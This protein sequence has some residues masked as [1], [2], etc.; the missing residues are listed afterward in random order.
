[1]NLTLGYVESLMN[2]RK[3]IIKL[4]SIFFILILYTMFIAPGFTQDND[5]ENPLLEEIV[6]YH[7]DPYQMIFDSAKSHDI[8]IYGEIHTMAY[9]KEIFAGSIKKLHFDYG[10]NYIA[11]EIGESCQDIINEY[12]E[13][14]N[15]LLLRKN[16]WTLFS[17]WHA[18]EQYLK[19]YKTVYQ[20]NQISERK[21]R[22]ICM[23]YD[24]LTYSNDLTLLRDR[25]RYMMEVLDREV[26]SIDKSA[27]LL[28]LIG[29]YHA[30]KSNV[31]EYMK[32]IDSEGLL[33]KNDPLGAFLQKRF[34]A[35]VFSFYIDGIIPDVYDDEGFFQT[36]I[37]ELYSKQML[38]MSAI[39]F[40]LLFD[41]IPEAFHLNILMKIPIEGNF[42]GYIFTGDSEELKRID[43]N[44]WKNKK[45]K[46]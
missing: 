3:T 21:M 6:R 2:N 28:I 40:A 45:D 39:P 33:F 24:P 44:K 23:D 5:S 27:K 41:R 46:G 16:P 17:P 37:S 11:L 14:G 42:D 19:I 38:T 10:F 32:D 15:E 35:K 30:V 13:T 26:F 7:I 9:P 22:I 34:P 31:W 29:A 36:S 1:M 43:I 18:S 25:D 8:L 20:I 4:I 12:L